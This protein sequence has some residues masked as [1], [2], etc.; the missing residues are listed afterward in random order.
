MC[1]QICDSPSK[2]QYVIRSGTLLYGVLGIA[3]PFRVVLEIGILS[4]LVHY[5][6]FVGCFGRVS[7]S[8]IPFQGRMVDFKRKRKFKER[9][10][11][12]IFLEAPFSNGN[13]VRDPIQFGRERQ[14]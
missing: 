13:H 5:R 11:V 3:P 14:S 2:L 8:S 7:S 4:E 6:A 10:K 12:P 1:C 9:I